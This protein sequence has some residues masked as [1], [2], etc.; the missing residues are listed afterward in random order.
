MTTYVN[1]CPIGQQETFSPFF[2]CHPCRTTINLFYYF[3][4]LSIPKKGSESPSP[5]EIL[6][7][8]LDARIL[9]PPLEKIQIIILNPSFKVIE[10]Q[11]VSLFVYSI[12]FPE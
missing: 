2:S 3:K 1:K 10:C 7:Q 11:S 8:G 6:G 5:L 9:P 12:A 4:P